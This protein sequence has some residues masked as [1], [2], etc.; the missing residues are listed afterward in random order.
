MTVVCSFR[1]APGKRGKMISQIA[2]LATTLSSSIATKTPLFS[3][4][5]NHTYR[6]VRA[7]HP[8]NQDTHLSLSIYIY[9]GRASVVGGFR[10][11]MC[12]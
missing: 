4:I 3:W 1:S 10:V 2:W 7:I 12:E 5:V 11:Y 8:V 9:V 6:H